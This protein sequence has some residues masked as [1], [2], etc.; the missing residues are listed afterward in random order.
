MA[1]IGEVPPAD[2]IEIGF[3]QPGEEVGRTHE[4]GEK[5]GDH[6]GWTTLSHGVH[7]K[8]DVAVAVHARADMGGAGIIGDRVGWAPIP[9][10]A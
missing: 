5:H 10:D 4:V 6:A 8:P 3:P 9:S 2:P 7:R 1:Q